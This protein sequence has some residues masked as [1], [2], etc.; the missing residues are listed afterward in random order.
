MTTTEISSE[1]LEEMLAGL[2]GVT[3]GPWFY[4]P[5]KFDDWGFVRAPT[6]DSLPGD[7]VC[8]AKY[9][10]DLEEA[11]L[12][13]HRRNRTDPV[14]PLGE[15]IARCD[16]DTMRSILTEL[17]RRRNGDEGKS[18]SVPLIDSMSE[19]EF[20][21]DRSDENP[22]VGKKDPEGTWSDG[23]KEWTPDEIS[24]KAG[25]DK[26]KQLLR[27]EDLDGFEAAVA[28]ITELETALAGASA[29]IDDIGHQIMPENID[30]LI[31]C[32]KNL[33]AALSGK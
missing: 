32:G 33:R 28:R 14:R 21:R 4:R 29:V 30:A 7:L 20:N 16:P 11:D 19:E 15:H 24:F 27:P 5:E 17:I 8:V 18:Q 26:A 22:N 10:I 31:T 9:S 12:D 2:E 13:E 25:W 23:R 1:R 3:S 6:P